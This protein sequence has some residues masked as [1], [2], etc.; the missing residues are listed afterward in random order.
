MIW[1]LPE[2]RERRRLAETSFESTKALGGPPNAATRPFALPVADAAV[3]FCERA[4]ILLLSRHEISSLQALV[5]GRFTGIHPHNRSARRDERDGAFR[6]GVYQVPIP[7]G[8]EPAPAE[9]GQ[10]RRM[11]AAGLGRTRRR[12]SC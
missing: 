1:C 7:A 2:A 11:L 6:E 3:P 12:F 4:V 5:G 10:F 8:F 9:A